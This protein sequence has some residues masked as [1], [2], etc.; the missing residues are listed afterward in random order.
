MT[1]GVW[2][3]RRITEIPVGRGGD[4]SRDTPP[5]IPVGHIRVFSGT[6]NVSGQSPQRPL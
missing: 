4:V 5:I 6:I 1:A 3:R 2:L